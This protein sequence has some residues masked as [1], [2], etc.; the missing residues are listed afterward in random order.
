MFK[1]V[2]IL[3]DLRKRSRAGQ[4]MQPAA[5]RSVSAARAPSG[6]V[7]MRH[8]YAHARVLAEQ[9]ALHGARTERHGR[10]LP[11]LINQQFFGTKSTVMHLN[12]PVL[13]GAVKTGCESDILR[14]YIVRILGVR[15]L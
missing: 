7:Q 9:V 5:R 13:G 14:K 6:T 3:K 11:R 8:S 1:I 12:Y 10:R 4:W 2:N 15:I